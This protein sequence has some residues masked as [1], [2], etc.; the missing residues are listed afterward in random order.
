VESHTVLKESMSDVGAKA[1]AADMGVSASLVYKWCQP[2]ELAGSGAENPLDR[3]L[4][5]CKSTGNKKPVLWLCEQLDGFFV[6]NTSSDSG[7][8][9]PWLTVTQE[10]L[11]EFSDLLEKV[12]GSTADD[13]VIDQSEAAAIRAEWEELKSVGESFVTACE[14]G[15]YGGPGRSP[16]R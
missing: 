3:I 6:E 4:K 5:I 1:V 11:S 16:A 9:E 12:S 15:V 2:K 7:T 10:I 13:G 8:K 14:R